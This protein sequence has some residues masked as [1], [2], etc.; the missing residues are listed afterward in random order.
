MSLSVLLIQDDQA[1]CDVEDLL[2]AKIADFSIEI[3]QTL[4]LNVDYSAFDLLVIKKNNFITRFKEQIAGIIVWED[5]SELSEKMD[6]YLQLQRYLK[7]N[8]FGLRGWTLKEVL[9]NSEASTI[10]HA[11][12]SASPIMPLG[13][14]VAIKSFKYKPQS[15]TTAKIKQFVTS[16]NQGSHLNG[17]VDIY[18]AGVTPNAFYLVMEYLNNGTLRQALNGCGNK[19][20]IVHAL[21]WFQEIVIALDAV[22]QKGL[23]HHDLKIDNI[24]LRSDGSL[25]LLDYG[26]SKRILLDSGYISE[27]ELHCSPHYVSPEQI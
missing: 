15:L 25:A 10:Y 9:H 26:V 20:P 8:P 16:I 11:V 1:S 27:G 14:S 17:L 3:Q 22:H 18:D 6:V 13:K 4:D 21:S 12:S 5:F 19:L 7:Q 2:S 24:L 23:I